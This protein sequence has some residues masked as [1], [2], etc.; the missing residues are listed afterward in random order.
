MSD[1][2]GLSSETAA[3][4][5]TEKPPAG[6]GVSVRVR[7]LAIALLPI[8]IMLPALAA[9]GLFWWTTQFDHLLIT[10]VTGD[11]TIA[12]QYLNRIME[13]DDEHLLAIGQSATFD[14]I[15]RSGSIDRLNAFLE[16]QR[17]EQKLDFLY[18]A[19]GNGRIVASAPAFTQTSDPRR[20]PAVDKALAGRTSTAIDL[21]QPQDLEELST[22]LAQRARISLL[23]TPAATPTDR[24]AE[25]RGLVVHTATPIRFPDA[26]SGAL[27]SGELLNQNLDFIDTINDLVYK[28]AS[29]PAGSEG[30]ATLF[31]DD[32]RISTNVRLFGN[33]RALGTRV[34]SAVRRAVLDEGRTWLDRAF[35]VNAWYI[36]AYEP[37]VD[38]RG[39]RVGM[40]YVGF[41]E[42]PFH[43]MKITTVAV[44][45]T[46]LIL[47]TLV[48]VPV[49]L[50]WISRIFLPLERMNETIAQVESG[51]LSAR[52]AERDST[53]E[54]GRVARHLDS[55]LDR[56]QERDRQLREWARV[57]DD[58][59][60][61]RT[62]ELQEANNRLEA[63]Q[64]QLV[65]SEKLAAIGEITA[66]VA[67]EINNPIA[68]IQGN[69]DV[70]REILGAEA[71][72]ARTEFMLIDQQVHR[73]NMIV[74]KLLQFARPA[75]FAGYL[76]RIAPADVVTD[77]LV[78]IQHHLNK[79]GIQVVRQDLARR[80]TSMN[81]TELQ[82]VVV[83]LLV[84]AVHAMPQGGT[85]TLRTVDADDEGQPGVMIAVEDTGIG[86]APDRLHRIFDA[87]VTSKPQQGT[88][89]GLSISYA[90]VTRAGGKL[91]VRSQLN[92]GSVFTIWLPQQAEE[93]AEG[94]DI[95]VPGS[96]SE[97]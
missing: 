35:V 64:Q 82:Q 73:I 41:L 80:T 52:T 32:V 59:V 5:T 4:P 71:D 13:R 29:L 58:R 44:M 27:V 77:C 37:I 75:E 15:L 78:L 54:I 76:D 87:F 28:A 1:R 9:L 56:L 26:R 97:S 51:D 83:N 84:N 12:R 23:K 42:K 55:L 79:S 48:T 10:K 19:D 93:Q 85:L 6:T 21:F 7:L 62:Q 47:I 14:D 70:A 61:E 39:Q 25:T 31:L 16:S 40:L 67:H 22:A 81:R 20:W 17:I 69:L 86:I 53:D 11:L 8:L 57:L 46:A 45:V 68:V 34:S 94:S 95:A 49:F 3:R 72:V 36:S 2:P 38:S 24:A 30:T 92:E 63:T 65:I 50:R 88:G 96:V 18:L 90:L 43:D 33:K 66:G 74:T 60:M 89:L 91:S